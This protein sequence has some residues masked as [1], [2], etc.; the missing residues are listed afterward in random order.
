VRHYEAGEIDTSSLEEDWTRLRALDEAMQAADLAFAGSDGP[1]DRRFDAAQPAGHRVYIQ[2]SGLLASARE[3]QIV[4]EQ[5]IHVIGHYPRAPWSLLRPAFES[6][7]WAWW[8]LDPD[9]SASRRQRAL[10]REVHDF[11]EQ[12]MYLNVLRRIPGKDRAQV[13]KEHDLLR[14]E[15]L[16]TYKREAHALGADFAK[17]TQKPDLVAALTNQVAATREDAQLVACR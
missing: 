15:S 8:I 6:A 13:Q 4:Y 10:G 14:A 5:L 9:D 17:L 11:N 3:H 12:G 16:R 1:C 7:F 2:A